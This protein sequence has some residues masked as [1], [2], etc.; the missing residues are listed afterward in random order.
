VKAVIV[1]AERQ[2]KEV[3]NLVDY[4]KDLDGTEVIV[5]PAIDETDEYPARNNYAFHQAARMMHGKPFFW[6]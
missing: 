2:H 1:A 3:S 5:I 6:L 4:I